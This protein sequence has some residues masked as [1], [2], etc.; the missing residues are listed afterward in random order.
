VHNFV[1]FAAINVVESKVRKVDI[2]LYGAPGSLQL[3]GHTHAT[4][5]DP[6]AAASEAG[7]RPP[8]AKILPP[9]W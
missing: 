4:A 8:R 6:Q 1:H 3:W 7:T 9:S 5:L 2:R